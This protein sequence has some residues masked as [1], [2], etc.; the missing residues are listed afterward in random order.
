MLRRKAVSS[1]EDLAVGSLK[2][3]QEKLFVF[4]SSHH[5]TLSPEILIFP[6]QISFNMFFLIKAKFEFWS[7]HP[8]V[9]HYKDTA[10]CCLEKVTNT[11]IDQPPNVQ[12]HNIFLCPGTL[13]ALYSCTLLAL[14]SSTFTGNVLKY[15]TSC[16]QLPFLLYPGTLQ[17]SY[18][19]TL[20]ATVGRWQGAMLGP[21][22][23]K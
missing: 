23:K 16:T 15:L 11:L 1:L 12:L 3:C 2:R 5:Q 21:A 7:I 22:W 19:G 14:Y 18:S 17:G 6:N 4:S 9:W 20:L 8:S 13:Q 10:L